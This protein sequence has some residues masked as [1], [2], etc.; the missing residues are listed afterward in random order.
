MTFLDHFD[1]KKEERRRTF[2]ITRPVGFAAGKNKPAAQLRG[3]K[4][5]IDE[6]LLQSDQTFRRKLPHSQRTRKLP[7]RSLLVAEEETVLIWGS[8]RPSSLHLS[9]SRPPFHS[10]LESWWTRDSEK[11]ENILLPVVVEQ[12]FER[13]G[14][15]KKCELT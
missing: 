4:A 6:P 2:T 7:G 1:R 8:A 5:E 15:I 12:E 11:V 10:P 14:S 3:R 9:R 13:I